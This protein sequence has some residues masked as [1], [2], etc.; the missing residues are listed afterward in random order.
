MLGACLAA[1]CAAYAVA[2]DYRA[3]VAAAHARYEAA[4]LARG[5]RRLAS[6]RYICSRK[7]MLRRNRVLRVRG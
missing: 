5:A 7:L 2:P 1:W 4:V 3:V 6:G